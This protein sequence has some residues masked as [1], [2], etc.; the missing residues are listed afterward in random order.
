V[1]RVVTRVV[2]PVE[3]RPAWLRLWPLGLIALIGLVLWADQSGLWRSSVAK[4]Q[5]PVNCSTLTQPAGCRVNVD[6]REIRFGMLGEPKPLAPFH[7]WLELPDSL[8]AQKA[9]ARFTMEGMDMGFNLYTLRPDDQGVL[10]ATV[11][12]PIC[13][14]GRR[15]WHMI[16]D[17][18][19][20]NI[21][22]AFV[23]NL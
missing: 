15:D 14:T 3:T 16:L 5:V 12:L 18:A 9:E 22:V 13:V 23:T 21:K 2:T 20:F 8:E 10:R 19:G 6:G 11:T 1:T 4:K 7:I 17:V